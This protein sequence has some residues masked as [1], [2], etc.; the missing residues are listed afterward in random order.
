MAQVFSRLILKKISKYDCVDDDF[1]WDMSV[2]LTSSSY[3]IQQD[4]DGTRMVPGRISRWPGKAYDDYTKRVTW[5]IF[6]FTRSKGEFQ[7]YNILPCFE[8]TKLMH[9]LIK[10][11]WNMAM[12]FAAIHELQRF[13][14]TALKNTME[15]T[16]LRIQNVEVCECLLRMRSSSQSQA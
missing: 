4:G 15:I 8:E 7:D 1:Y 13:A 14:R 10:M 3:L 5:N 11:S 6:R 9:V 2:E 16:P 12:D